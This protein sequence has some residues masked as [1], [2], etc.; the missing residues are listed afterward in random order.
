MHIRFSRALTLFGILVIGGA[1]PAA[2]EVFCTAD[3]RDP[4]I[5]MPITTVLPWGAVGYI[6]NGCTATLISQSYILTAGHCVANTDNASWQQGLDFFPNFHPSVTRPS[7][8]IDRAVVGARADVQQLDWA[9]A[10]LEQPEAG[11]VGRVM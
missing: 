11:P 4:R 10:H 6:N 9:I 1:A 3:G 7:V 8:R 2:A 5:Q